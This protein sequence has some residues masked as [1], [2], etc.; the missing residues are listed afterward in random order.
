M[1]DWDEPPAEFT[2][3]ELMRIDPP[4]NARRYYR[5]AWEPTLFDEYA[6]TRTYGRRGVWRRTRTIPF[7]TLEAAWPLIRAS[8]KAR[9]RHGYIVVNNRP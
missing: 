6:V 3:V 8:I 1:M 5:I 4:A 9:L 2:A 7:P